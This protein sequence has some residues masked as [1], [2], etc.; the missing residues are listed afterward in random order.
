M[1]TLEGL[2]KTAIEDNAEFLTIEYKDGF[3]EVTAYSGGIGVTIDAIK[4][5]TKKSESLFDQI[6]KVE[7][8]N[9]ITIGNTEVLLKISSYD[10]FR[11]AAYEIRILRS[12]VDTVH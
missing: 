8:K 9:R 2:L 5:N 1:N 4:S 11:E 10:N 7:K 6:K 3:E 12:S